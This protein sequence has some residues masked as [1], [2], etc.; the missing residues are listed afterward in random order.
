MVVVVDRAAATSVVDDEAVVE[1]AAVIDAGANDDRHV[2][3]G[4]APLAPPHHQ[5]QQ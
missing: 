5:Q 2:A 4:F 1:L 3:D